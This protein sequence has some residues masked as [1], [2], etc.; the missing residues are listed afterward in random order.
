[1]E[2]FKEKFNVQA[3]KTG[4]FFAILHVNSHLLRVDGLWW[5][6]CSTQQKF[7]YVIYNN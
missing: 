6:L 4:H 2:W 7:M 1:M 5:I 3:A